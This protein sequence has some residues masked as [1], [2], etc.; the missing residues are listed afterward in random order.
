MSW[1]AGHPP[2]DH[3]G[4]VATDGQARFIVA[5][6]VLADEHESKALLPLLDETAEI[7]GQMPRHTLA[8]SAF[9]TPENL[10]GLEQRCTDAYIAPWGERLE[11]KRQSSSAQPNVAHRDDLSV[12]VPTELHSQLPMTSKGRLATEAFV[13]QEKTDCYWCPMGR[14]LPLT[15][16]NREN[17]RTCDRRVYVCGS[18]QGCPLRSVCTTP[19]KNRW[20]RRRGTQPR[21]EAMAAKVHSEAGRKIYRQR[22]FVAECPNRVTTSGTGGSVTEDRKR[23]LGSMAYGG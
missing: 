20:I 13:Y 7:H 3:G 6:T 2:P 11:G 1:T 23:G 22:Q 15:Y 8:D 21:R 14:S 4:C 19:K 5:E 18:C 9:C 16:T 12:A 17:G 10:E